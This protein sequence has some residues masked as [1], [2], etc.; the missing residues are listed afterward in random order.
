M[1]KI[2]SGGEISRLMLALKT[3]V[4]Q[5]RGNRGARGAT[6]NVPTFIFDEVDGGFGGRVAESVGQ[7]PEAAGP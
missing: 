7:R 3:V 6:R 1:E 5:S 4:G 2:A